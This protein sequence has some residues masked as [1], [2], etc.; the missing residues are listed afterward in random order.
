VQEQR[1]PRKR[2]SPIP[3]KHIYAILLG[4]VVFGGGVWLWQG[5]VKD[6]VVPKRFGVVCD[7]EV[8]RSGRLSTLLVKKTLAKHRIAVIVDLTGDSPDSSEQQAEKQAARELGIERLSY[9][10]KGDGTGDI[11]NYA[12][13]VAAIVKARQEHKPVLVHCAAGAQ[14]TGGVIAAYQLLV[15]GR[16]P[17]AVCREMTHYGWDPQRNAVLSTY[18]ND[19]MAELAGL[20]QQMGVIPAPP[21]PIPQLNCGG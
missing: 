7:G 8:Y 18:L 14:R 2:G 19:H 17:Q 6:W 9:P 20:L 4:M 5:L 21:H 12:R 11:N 3:R 13:A 1:S 10:L 16:D 15:E